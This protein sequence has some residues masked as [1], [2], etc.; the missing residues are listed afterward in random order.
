MSAIFAQQLTGP[1][2]VVDLCIFHT[3]DGN[4]HRCVNLPERIGTDLITGTNRNGPIF[5]SIAS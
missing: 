2:T 4:C 1:L 5:F 3:E